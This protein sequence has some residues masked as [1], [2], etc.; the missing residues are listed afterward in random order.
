MFSPIERVIAGQAKLPEPSLISGI[1][2][3]D[4]GSPLVGCEVLA[5]HTGRPN[6]S[7]KLAVVI[8]DSGWG[9]DD[10]RGQQFR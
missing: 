9:I 6:R 10:S 4:K 5:E 7:R 1:I 8:G 2:V 3:A